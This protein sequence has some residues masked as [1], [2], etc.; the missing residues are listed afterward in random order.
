MQKKHKI[1]VDTNLWVSFL[2][3]RQFDFL[4]A[5]LDDNKAVLV[6]SQEL[7]EEFVDVTQRPKLKPFFRLEDLERLLRIVDEK[8]M[9]Y[10]VNSRVDACRDDKDNFLLSLAKDSKADYLITGD[11]D[12]LVLEEFERTK[13][14]TIKEYESLCSASSATSS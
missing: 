6:F 9:Y 3:T 11:K 4:D 8:A 5:L 12:L 1:I 2:L 10:V 14:I 7:L 13:I